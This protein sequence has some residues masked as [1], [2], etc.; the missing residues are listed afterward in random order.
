MNKLVT[1]NTDNPIVYNVEKVKLNK[2]PRHF[3]DEDRENKLMSIDGKKVKVMIN[4]ERTQYVA[5]SLNEPKPD[6]PKF[7]QHYYVRDHKFFDNDVVKTYVKP[8][9]TPKV[10]EKSEE[11]K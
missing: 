11:T 8:T 9:P 3:G 1:L 2:L 10:E 4:R 5:F 7:I 6:N